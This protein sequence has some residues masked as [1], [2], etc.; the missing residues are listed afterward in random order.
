MPRRYQLQD[1]T[2]RI[3]PKGDRVDIEVTQ[4]IGKGTTAV[5]LGLGTDRLAVLQ[6]AN[7]ERQ[8]PA[9]VGKT[10]LQPGETVQDASED[11]LCG[12]DR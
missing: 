7:Q 3:R 1:E 10:E 5:V 11:Q 9:R 2:K 4:V 12:S 8:D 6:P